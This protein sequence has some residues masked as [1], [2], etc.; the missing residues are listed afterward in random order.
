MKRLF[1]LLISVFIYLNTYGEFPYYVGKII[2]MPKPCDTVS[3][4]SGMVWGVEGIGTYPIALSAGKSLICS[5]KKLVVDGVE[6]FIDDTVLINGSRIP[7]IMCTDS[8]HYYSISYIT[9]KKFS[10][11]NGNIQHFLGTYSITA[12]CENHWSSFSE[13]RTV[14]IEKGVDSDLLIRFSENRWWCSHPIY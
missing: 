10:Y 11:Y 13:T 5:D 8:T 1:L 9:I 2:Y 4:A 7:I 6:Y 14:V 3:C 12:M